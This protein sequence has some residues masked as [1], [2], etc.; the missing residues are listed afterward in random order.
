MQ[1]KVLVGTQ[2]V[3]TKQYSQFHPPLLKDLEVKAYFKVS[4]ERA[5]SL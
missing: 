1:F 3:P 4:L 2:R 5:I